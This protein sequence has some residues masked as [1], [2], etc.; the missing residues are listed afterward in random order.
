[1]LVLAG[2]PSC[3][4]MVTGVKI[5]SDAATDSGPDDAL[6]DV[7]T[8]AV[9]LSWSAVN[10]NI[11]DGDITAVWGASAA[12]VYVGTDLGTIYHLSSGIPATQPVADGTV[13]GGGWGSDP[14]N[15]YA[16]GANAWL[17]Q[18]G[19]SSAGGLYQLGA[20]GFWYESDR[21][22]YYTV[23]G[24]SSS[25]VYAAGPGGVFHSI[26]GGPFAQEASA[27][28]NALAVAGSSATD[29]YA[30]TTTAVLHSAGDGNWQVV[31][32]PSG[33][34]W[35]VW[36][37]GSG[38]AFALDS[39]ASASGATGSVLHARAGS[40]WVHEPVST[41]FT[42][43]VTLWGSGPNDV[44]AGGWQQGATGKSGVLYHSAGDGQWSPVD[45][46]GSLYDV[47]SVWGSSAFDVYVAVFDIDSG[48]VL[49]H[50]Q[51]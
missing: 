24:S 44:Y 51:L 15:V 50:G 40:R 3:S 4:G 45:L 28:T 22:T 23:W 33:L 16:P 48:P 38:D 26:A 30:T 36:T 43:L 39:P 21:G 8:I 46:P 2:T 25:D 13:F 12:D 19:L 31:A 10:A 20:D 35:A 34:A 17:A 1:M 47:R 49:L 32:S 7:P 37:S 27:G 9:P 29:V 14:Q 42:K 11:V 18:A 6:A 5:A 41:T